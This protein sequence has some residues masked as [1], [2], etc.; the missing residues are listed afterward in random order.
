MMAGNYKRNRVVERLLRPE[1]CKM[2]G[3]RALRT[4]CAL[5]DEKLLISGRY[6]QYAL[7]SAAPPELGIYFI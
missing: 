3:S 6:C 1:K 7:I 2:A 4:I 5:E